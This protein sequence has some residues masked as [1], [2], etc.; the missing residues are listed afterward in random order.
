MLTTL[1]IIGASLLQIFNT[2]QFFRLKTDK[3]TFYWQ[4]FFNAAFL[5]IALT[6]ANI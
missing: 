1:F 2:I 6:L 3:A 4:T 5:A